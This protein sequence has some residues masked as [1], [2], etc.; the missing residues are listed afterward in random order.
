M[1]SRSVWRNLFSTT[2]GLTINHVT[3]VGAGGYKA[4]AGWDGG[5][6]LLIRWPH[7]TSAWRKSISANER[8]S[9][10]M[11]TCKPV[12]RLPWEWRVFSPAGTLHSSDLD[13]V[14]SWLVVC[15]PVYGHLGW[16]LG[17]MVFCSEG[18]DI[19]RNRKSTDDNTHNLEASVQTLKILTAETVSEHRTFLLE[20]ELTQ[21][22]KNN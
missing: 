17:W 20:F 2:D 11:A 13:C 7:V 21:L 15:H 14:T 10:A 18:I 9:E 22:L 12:Q 19:N 8:P 4:K 6:T 1:E 3:W 16:F 5:W